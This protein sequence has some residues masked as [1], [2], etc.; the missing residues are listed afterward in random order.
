[1]YLKILKSS[2]ISENPY[3]ICFHSEE[4]ETLL[5]IYFFLKSGC[6]FSFLLRNDLNLIWFS[7]VFKLAKY[8]EVKNARQILE[9]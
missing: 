4:Y 9:D 1:M 3:I 7:K 8:Y 6:A 5:Y 2:L